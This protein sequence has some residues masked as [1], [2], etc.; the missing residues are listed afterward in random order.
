[1]N[2]KIAW[3]LSDFLAFVLP[4]AICDETRGKGRVFIPVTFL[5]TNSKLFVRYNNDCTFLCI[6]R[7]M[8]LLCEHYSRE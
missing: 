2:E 7:L 8:K 4:M 6:T 3:Q 5:G 1:M